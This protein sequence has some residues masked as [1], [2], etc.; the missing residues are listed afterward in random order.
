MGKIPLSLHETIA[1]NIRAERM[2]KFPGRGGSKQCAEAIFQFIGKNVSP[3]QWSPWERGRR[4]PDETRLEQMATF[5]GRTV[6]YMRRDTS[7]RVPGTPDSSASSIASMADTTP[8]P[9]ACMSTPELLMAIGR[10]RMKAVYR[11]E[12][13]VS[14]ARFIPCGEG[15]GK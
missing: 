15:G 10:D 13:Y 5:F 7:P 12:I 4:T 3:Q 2:K 9:Y 8:P 1:R 11:V 6:E 14:V